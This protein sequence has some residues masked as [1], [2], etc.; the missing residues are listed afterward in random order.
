MA[1]VHDCKIANFFVAKLV[2]EKTAPEKQGFHFGYLELLEGETAPRRAAIYVTIATSLGFGSGALFTSGCLP[3][4]NTL[5]PLSYYLYLP[6]TVVVLLAV[7]SVHE[8]RTVRTAA[9]IRLPH[10]QRNLMVHCFAIFF[11]WAVTGMVIA[12]VPSELAVRDLLAW[13]G[14]TLFLVNGVGVLCQPA[15]RKMEPDR[16]LRLG[17]ILAPFGYVLLTLGVWLSWVWL[18]LLG[19]AVSGSACYGFTYLGGLASVSAN[20]QHERA[21]AISGYFLFAYLG[22][23]LPVIL[24][25]FLADWLGGMAGLL[26]FGAIVLLGNLTIY[27]SLKNRAFK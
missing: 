22:F 15:A 11:A 5:T 13:S 10:F 9:W 25:G 19:A 1:G 23:S 4:Q 20:A 7:M 24:S 8:Q 6:L 21:R 3:F 14:L 26:V 16:A 18:I 2:K 17:L 12:I 27:L